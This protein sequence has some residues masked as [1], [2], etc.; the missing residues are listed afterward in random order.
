MIF[1]RE[2]IQEKFLY[3]LV[4]KNQIFFYIMNIIKRG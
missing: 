2:S 4:D 3:F 1:F